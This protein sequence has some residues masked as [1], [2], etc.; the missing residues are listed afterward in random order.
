MGIADD[1]TAPR[2]AISG[3]TGYV[4]HDLTSLLI[5]TGCRV[6]GL[7]RHPPSAVAKLPP[8]AM[9]RRI[10]DRT[11]T[12]CEHFEEFRPDIV[13]HLAALARRS[14]LVTDVTPFLEANVLLGARMLEAMRICGCRRF[15][16]AESILQFSDTGEP[17]AMNLYAAT[18]L[19]FAEILG[20]YTSAF[21][22]SAIA[23]VLPTL[24]SERETRPKLMTDIA[25]A[26]LN[27]TSVDVQAGD[28]KVDFVHTEDVASAVARAIEILKDR[29]PEPG[30]LR[31]Y[32]ISSGRNVTTRELITL[33]EHL[34]ERKIDVRWRHSQVNSRRANPWC[35][36]ILPGWTPQIDLET[37][38]KRMLSRQR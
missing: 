24:Y 15:I 1:E 27:G 8:T 37:G 14:H 7:I 11:E 31:R 17:R 28:V 4:G 26:L 2:I 18:K 22:V 35:G 25:A 3:I 38:I 13:V 36:P 32:W 6:L 29:T 21:G 9:L 23:L 20:Y 33:F 34:G 16:T 30:S 19:A 5:K 12:L 10:D